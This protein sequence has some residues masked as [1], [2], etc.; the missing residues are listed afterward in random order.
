MLSVPQLTVTKGTLS[1][2]PGKTHLGLGHIYS[3]E[4]ATLQE[5]EEGDGHLNRSL[6]HVHPQGGGS[7]EQFLFSRRS[8][9]L[10][11]PKEGSWAGKMGL[12]H[13]ELAE[14]SGLCFAKVELSF[15]PKMHTVVWILVLVLV[16]VS[17]SAQTS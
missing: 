4:P 17:I 1:S 15:Q 9:W 3:L 5:V 11:K 10:V 12:H 6:S 8:T 13:L 14:A 7:R 2:N 16:M